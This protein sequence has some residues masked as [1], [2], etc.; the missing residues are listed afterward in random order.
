MAAASA[1]ATPV[2]VLTGNGRATQEQLAGSLADIA[3]F[4]NLAAA[5]ADIV[6]TNLGDED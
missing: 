6:E 1:G 3:V 5:A 4:E 2:L